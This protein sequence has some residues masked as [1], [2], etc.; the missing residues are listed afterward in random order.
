MRGYV[1]IARINQCARVSELIL[2]REKCGGRFDVKQEY[3][4]KIL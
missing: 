3:E 4:G 1:S 2:T